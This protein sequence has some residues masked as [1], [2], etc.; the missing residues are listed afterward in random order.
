MW[1]GHNK[2]WHDKEEAWIPLEE[3]VLERMSKNGNI[4]GSQ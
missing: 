1:D 4:K 3:I 2:I